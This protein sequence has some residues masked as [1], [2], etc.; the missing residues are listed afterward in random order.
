MN[1]FINLSHND[2]DGAGSNLVLR[3]KF[4]DIKTYHVAYND[5][6]EHLRYIDVDITHHTKI[7]FITDLSFAEHD[8]VELVRL[9]MRHTH[10]TFVYIDHHHYEGERGVLFEKIKKVPNIKVKHEIGTS[11]TKL[12]YQFTKSTHEDLGKLVDWIDAFDIWR[13]DDPKFQV[14]FFLNTIFW[15]FKMSG[16]KYQL[17]AEDYK[18]PASFKKAYKEIINDKNEYVKSLEANNLILKNDETKVFVAFCDRHKSFFQMDFPDYQIHVLPYISKSNISVRLNAHIPE[19]DAHEFRDMVIDYCS[20]FPDYI[21]GGGH[22]HAFGITVEKSQPEHQK[23]MMVQGVAQIADQF[24]MD[25][26]KI[27]RE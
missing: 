14:G 1:E 8:L 9:A 22:A 26:Y 7:V 25:G 16:F 21:S 2:M 20:S 13:L 11:G 17:F 3:E 12:T 19:A 15:E 6:S 18:I 23:L 5:I 4:P 24:S 10:V 27:I